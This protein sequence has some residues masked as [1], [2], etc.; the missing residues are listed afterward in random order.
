MSRYPSNP[1]LP[2][3]SGDDLSF[4]IEEWHWMDAETCGAVYKLYS[5]ISRSAVHTMYGGGP[6]EDPRLPDDGAVLARVVNVSTR[7]F[8][9]NLRPKIEK[10]FL[11]RGGY[12]RIANPE[13]VKLTKPMKRSPLPADLKSFVL[14]R[15]GEFC[16]YCGTDEGPF[17]HDHLFPHSKGGRDDSGNLVLACVPCNSSKGDKT[18]ME[19]V[20]FLRER[21]D[22]Q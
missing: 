10:Y 18:L 21:R 6:H 4:N 19:W 17:H 22:L 12:W 14:K 5:A 3:P 15:Q 9:A 11:I 13:W 16:A 1:D 7:H 2:W 20:A 8:N